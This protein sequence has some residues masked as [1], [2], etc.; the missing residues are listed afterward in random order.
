M[1]RDR[2]IRRSCSDC[3]GPN[4]QWPLR[5]ELTGL[6][7][8][9][10]PS[11]DNFNTETAYRRD[12]STGRCQCG[13]LGCD[14][15][16]PQVDYPTGIV[17]TA[18]GNQ[19]GNVGCQGQPT[20]GG[21]I[22]WSPSNGR[23]SLLA[24][25]QTNTGRSATSAPVEVQVGPSSGTKVDLSLFPTVSSG[26]SLLASGQVL[27]WCLAINLPLAGGLSVPGGPSSRCPRRWPSRRRASGR[28]C[29]RPGRCRWQ[30]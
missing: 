22:R 24:S 10:Q 23:Y 15:L 18:N 5:N 7:N 14:Q 13:C 20:C 12:T 25:I 11:S 16:N 3:N 26:H 6:R 27:V 17:V 1:E 29:G 2:F 8:C 9:S 19:I 28:R 21:S 4:Q 30:L